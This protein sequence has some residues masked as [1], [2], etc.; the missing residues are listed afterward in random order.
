MNRG[1]A[2]VLLAAILILACLPGNSAP[3]A[4]ARPSGP[5]T[6]AVNTSCYFSTAASDRNGD[7]LAYRFSWGDGTKSN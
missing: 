2:F 5:I 7:S 3:D 1:F 4:P 6:A